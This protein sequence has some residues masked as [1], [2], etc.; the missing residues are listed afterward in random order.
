[1]N[2]VLI[3]LSAVNYSQSGPH[4]Y[5]PLKFN[6]LKFI[7]FNLYFAVNYSQSGPHFYFPLK[8]NPLKFKFFNLYFAANRSR[9]GPPGTLKGL[10]TM[11]PAARF[12]SAKHPSTLSPSP[13]CLNTTPGPGPGPFLFAGRG[14]FCFSGVC[15]LV[16]FALV[17]R[18]SVCGS[19][20]C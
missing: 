2:Q 12:G 19:G 14:G 1:M 20:Y 8:F 10:L 6:P 18:V 11:V 4:F 16:C 17:F 9:S 5:F 3:N 15:V 7:F 13:V